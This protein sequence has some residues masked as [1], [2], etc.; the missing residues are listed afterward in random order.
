MYTS[1]LNEETEKERSMKINFTPYSLF[2]ASSV[3]SIRGDILEIIAA[4]TTI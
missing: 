1:Y 3:Y 4:E 2:Y